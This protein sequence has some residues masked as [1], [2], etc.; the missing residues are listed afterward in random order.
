MSEY[1]ARVVDEEL[2]TLLPSLTALS[3]EGP[4]A[5]G[6]TET[7][8]RRANT[9]YRLDDPAQRQVIE[10]EPARIR[11]GTPPI[12]IDEWQRV[13]Q[14]WDVVRRAVDEDSTAGR[15]LLTGSATPAERP[16]HSGAGRIVTLRMRPLTLTERGLEDPTVSL[17]ELLTGKRPRAEGRTRVTLTDYVDAI[18]ESGYPGLR[19]L[20]GRPLRAQLDGYLRR[21]ADVE[22]EQLGRHVRNPETL[23]RWMRAYAAATSTTASYETIR[24]AA[25]AGQADK[26]A[27]STTIPYREILERLWI[28]DPIPAWIPSRNYFSRLSRSPKHHLADPA[29]AARLLG[30]GRGG[31]LEGRAGRPAIPRDGTL[32]GH[33]FESLLAL[34]LRVYA[35]P[36]E[37]ELSHFRLR[38]GRREVDL[39]LERDDR[40]VLAIEV[41]L[42]RVVEDADVRHLLW[43]GERL[44]DD[45]LDAVVL[46]TG[47]EAYRRADGVAVVPA[48]L[49]GP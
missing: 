48:A 28:L 3:L 15:F 24:D 25:T 39:L 33:L 43:L 49:L 8:L 18:L 31:L 29:L 35:Q 5:V 14:T 10:A 12:L 17:R 32:L 2:D 42:G 47:P 36:L 44:G 4:K 7:A 20:D 21:I 13:P 30:V 6:K 23:R 34:C 38:G 26:P 22:F 46:T 41:K 37:A 45:L 1:I 40:R 9:V 16:T 11:E 19:H 27:K